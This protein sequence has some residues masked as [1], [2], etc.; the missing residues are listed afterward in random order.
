MHFLRGSGLSGL[1]GMLPKRG[2]YIRPLLTL[3]KEVLVQYCVHHSIPF[4]IDES[5]VETVYLRNKVRHE[6][7]PLLEKEYNPA[8]GSLHLVRLCRL[9]TPNFGRVLSGSQASTLLF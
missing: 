5:N 7:I 8:C 6:L 1:K 3:S 4:A 2:M 9:K